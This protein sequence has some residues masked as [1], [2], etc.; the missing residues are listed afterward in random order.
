MRK[1]ILIAVFTCIVLTMAARPADAAT[2]AEIA[3][4]ARATPEVIDLATEVARVP[5][6][7]AEIL[8]LPLG[9]G[10]V[11]L[12]P[13]P[14]IDAVDGLS[15]VGK[16]LLAPI[17]LGITVLRLPFKVLQKGGSVIGLIPA[18]AL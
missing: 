11:L 6:T 1:N 7:A 16:G 13:L 3:A 10:E 15:H 12:S 17:K 8:Y 14:G 18:G 5:F 9:T 2:G 4:A